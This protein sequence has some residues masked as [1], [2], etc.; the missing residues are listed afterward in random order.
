MWTHPCPP[1]KKKRCGD[2]RKTNTLTRDGAGCV[3]RGLLII[4]LGTG[5]MNNLV[6]IL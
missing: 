1:L 4:L 6:I 5:S 2:Q 3:L